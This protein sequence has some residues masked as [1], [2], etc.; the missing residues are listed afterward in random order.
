M[1][2]EIFSKL[3]LVTILSLFSTII[4]LYAWTEPTANPPG[5]NVAAPINVSISTQYKAGALGI[6]GVLRGYSDAIFEGNITSKRLSHNQSALQVCA[7]SSGK[8]ILCSGTT[9]PPPPPPSSDNVILTITMDSQGR[10]ADVFIFSSVKNETCNSCVSKSFTFPRG[11]NVTIEFRDPT[12]ISLYPPPGGYRYSFSVRGDCGTQTSARFSCM[13]DR[14]KS[15]VYYYTG[16]SEP[17][18]EEYPPRD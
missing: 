16:L 4:F 12:G 9:P 1:L 18:E 17:G 13:L 14:D 2:K 7:D 6:G 5:G 11:T 8:L 15:V 10:P 3:I